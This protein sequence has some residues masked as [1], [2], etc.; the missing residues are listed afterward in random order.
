MEDY[1][2]CCM[3]ESGI[4]RSCGAAPRLAE[5]SDSVA[6]GYDLWGCV[7]RSVIDDDDLELRRTWRASGDRTQ[8]VADGRLAVEHWHHDADRRKRLHDLS[9]AISAGTP[10]AVE[11]TPERPA[12]QPV[13]IRALGDSI[14]H[15]TEALAGG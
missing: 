2:A 7:C 11:P 6:T 3:A 4:P 9:S 8:H 15:K 1:L 14:F 10:E 5:Q 13:V 12:P